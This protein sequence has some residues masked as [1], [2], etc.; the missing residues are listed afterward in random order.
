MKKMIISIVGCSM[1]FG[2]SG[3]YAGA[4]LQEIKA[5]LNNDIKVKVNGKA[6]QLVDAKGKAVTPITYNGST[7]L[8]VR[9]I[10]SSLSVAVDFDTATNSVLIGEKVDGTPLNAAQSFPLSIKDPNLTKYRG[11]D[12][13]EVYNVREDFHNANFMLTPNKK[14]QT[15]YLQIAAIDTE[16]EIAVQDS[17]GRLLKQDNVT[18]A[19]GLKTIEVKV[20]QEDEVFVFYKFV[21]PGK[22]LGMFVPLSTSYY[23]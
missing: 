8:P 10:S 1:L 14:F 5:Y 7:Y 2:A 19:D 9:A 15:L 22:N 17:E 20:A 6:V 16:I 12:Y 23:K 13:T 21:N 18:E 3:V 11:K 4:H